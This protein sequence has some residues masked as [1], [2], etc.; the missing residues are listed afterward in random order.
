MT[1]WIVGTAGLFLTT[2]G[3]LLIFLYLWKSPRLADNA[4]SPEKKGPYAPSRGLLI[5]AVA[6][7]AVWFVLQYLS[8]ILA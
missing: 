8:V 5:L 1:T 6:L 4:Q 7:I 3:V 2:A